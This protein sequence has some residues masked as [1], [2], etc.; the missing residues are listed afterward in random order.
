M[1]SFNSNRVT[2][3]LNEYRLKVTGSLECQNDKL[4]YDFIYKYKVNY[5]A[6]ILDFVY[7][8][9]YEDGKRDAL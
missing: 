3:L 4:I 1:L 7:Q 2:E 6:E 8:K 5:Q 9:A